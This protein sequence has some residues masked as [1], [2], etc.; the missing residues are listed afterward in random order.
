MIGSVRVLR[1]VPPRPPLGFKKRMGSEVATRGPGTGPVYIYGQ[2]GTN[3]AP[4]LG[5]C[6]AGR[7]SGKKRLPAAA[8]RAG[9]QQLGG[10]LELLGKKRAAFPSGGIEGP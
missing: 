4:H 6:N 9:R 3:P 1:T 7:H 10:H 2:H 8:P 5:A